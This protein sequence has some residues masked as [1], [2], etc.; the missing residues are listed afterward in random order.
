[1]T[2]IGKKKMIPMLVYLQCAI[3]LAQSF[4]LG[5]ARAI[6][7]AVAERVEGAMPVPT[8]YAPPE[9]NTTFLDGTTWCVAA[10]GAPQ[11]D[12]QKA[13][14]WACGLGMAECKEIQEEGACF[15][16]NNL[17]SHASYAFNSYYQQ[18]GN[19]DIACN[20][21]GA[22][23]LTKHDPSFLPYMVVW[24]STVQW[25]TGIYYRA[26]ATVPPLKYWR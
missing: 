14:D 23:S 5:N 21:G 17:V 19:S 3:L 24:G 2:T 7:A 9:G 12:L 1:M 10:A 11:I 26:S 20:F 6:E 25:K 18:N 16:P 15:H 4:H 8:T 22:A 13:L